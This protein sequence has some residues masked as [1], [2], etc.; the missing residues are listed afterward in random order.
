MAGIVTKGQIGYEDIAT[1]T[2]TFTRSTSTGGSQTLHQLPFTVAGG[3]PTLLGVPVINGAII[4]TSTLN[5]CTLTSATLNTCTLNT[6]TLAS[7]VINGTPSGTGI[8]T[9][10]YKSGGGIG[11]YTRTSSTLAAVDSTNLS[12]TVTIPTGWKLVVWA[13]GGAEVSANTTSAV[14][15]IRDT[16]LAQIFAE[17][18]ANIAT[19]GNVYPFS[20]CAAIP[21]DGSSHTV[22][23]QFASSDNSSTV[24][25]PNSGSNFPTM[26]F[27]LTPSN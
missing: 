6:A 26:V 27:L 11:N 8:P 13:S 12:L 3:N 25:I 22:Q 9:V 24:T 23:L 5:T 15:A 20:L 18:S 14:L 2:S 19:A 7:P 10:T 1:G 17:I 16:F 4:T 21:G